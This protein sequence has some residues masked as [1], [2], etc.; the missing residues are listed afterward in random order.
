M[1]RP[2]AKLTPCIPECKNYL[3]KK[4]YLSQ[5]VKDKNFDKIFMVGDG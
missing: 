3:C 1:Y 5:Y 2:V 4:H